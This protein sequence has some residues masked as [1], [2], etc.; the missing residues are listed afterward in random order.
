[1]MTLDDL[2]VLDLVI[3]GTSIVSMLIGAVRGFVREALSLAVWLAAFLGANLAAREAGALFAEWISDESLQVPVGFAAVFVVTLALGNLAMNLLGML[4]DATG[5]TGLDRTL[6]TLFG[7]ARA[8]VLGV[9]AVAFAEP[10]L[11]E[12]SWWQASRFVPYLVEAQVETFD[13]FDRIADVVRD[14]FGR[15]TDSGNQLRESG[16]NHG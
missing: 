9:V 16:V 6:G 3:L 11:G 7:A 2:A 1:M 5:L 15:A 13:A 14:W 8:A 12:T 10:L 4:I